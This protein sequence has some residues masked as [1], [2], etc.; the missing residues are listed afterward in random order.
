MQEDN[1][2]IKNK[3]KIKI[4][5]KSKS[6]EKHDKGFFLILIIDKYHIYHILN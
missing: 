3:N 4:K 2:I 1:N 6:K 5:I